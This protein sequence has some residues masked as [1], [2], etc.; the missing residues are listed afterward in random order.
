M[1]VLT[2]RLAA[3][4]CLA[5]GGLSWQAVFNASS[6]AQAFNPLMDT[7]RLTRTADWLVWV[8]QDVYLPAGWSAAFSAG[9]RYAL[10]RWPSAMVAGVY[11]VK[12]HG[13]AAQRCGHV[14]DR[15]RM[16][17]EST[18]LPCTV[19][20]LDELLVAVRVD[21]I[22]RMDTALGFDFYATDL[23]LQAQ[24]RGGVAVAI[25]APCE[26]WSDTP[27]QPPVPPALRKRLE[28]S[29]EVFERKW[30]HRLPVQTPCFAIHAPG[31]V[32]RALEGL[33]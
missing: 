33:A 4:P 11:G 5:P 1:D 32:A 6:A 31:D 30:V 17:H 20:S 22:L 16:L 19:D 2:Q 29:A 23:V 12:G 3:S 25:D 21:S 27:M 26:H 28:L 8:H 10:E 9:L 13:S 24:E 15:G 7:L 14:L 18:P